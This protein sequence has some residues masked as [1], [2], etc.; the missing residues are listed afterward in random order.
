[1]SEEIKQVMEFKIPELTRGEK[2]VGLDKEPSTNKDVET[3]KRACA[4]LIDVLDKELIDAV[5][6]EKQNI[7]TE[8]IDK[9]ATTY[10]ELEK[11]L[12]YQDK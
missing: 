6:S 10:Q 1:M 3:C 9:V 2:L 5:S 7:L 4:Y 12:T 8:T 11:A